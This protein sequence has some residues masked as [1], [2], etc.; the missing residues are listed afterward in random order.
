MPKERNKCRN[1]QDDLAQ[2]VA[3]NGSSGNQEQI[4]SLKGLYG[5]QKHFSTFSNVSLIKGSFSKF[6][7]DTMLC[8]HGC[9]WGKGWN[10]EGPGET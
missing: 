8:G 6:P 3:I 4:V 9:V 1:W 2:G 7:D 10:P 5:D